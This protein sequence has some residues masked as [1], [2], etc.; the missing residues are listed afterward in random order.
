MPTTRRSLGA[1]KPLNANI[2][3][4]TTPGSKVSHLKAELEKKDSENESLRTDIQNLAK[5][6]GKLDLVKAAQPV[7]N[8]AETNGKKDPKAPAP[9]KTA[10]KYFCD[11]TPAQDNMQQVWKETDATKRQPFVKLAAAD[12]ERYQNEFAA[13]KEEKQAMDMY[14][15][16]KKQDQA[17]AFY[18]AHLEA[19][20]ALNKAEAD[21][22][23]KK[24]MKD[25]NAPKRPTSSY[26]YYAMD[27]RGSVVVTNPDAKPTEIT[28]M[29]GS[30]WNNLE[31]KKAKKFEKMAETDRQRYSAEKQAYDAKLAAQ[32]AEAEKEEMARLEEEKKEAMELLEST[33]KLAG[34]IKIDQEN[35]SVVSEISAK[36]KKDPNAPK[37]ALTAYN[38]FFT[39]NR[40]NIKSKMPAETTNG[41]L[42]TEVG[43][44]WKALAD[45]KKKKYNK[46]AEKDKVRYT[47]EVAKY[48]ASKE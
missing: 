41:E 42:M 9:A 7:V 30:M 43:R 22:N 21:K 3:A 10:Y 27:T 2:P 32:K 19:Q 26:M 31:K 14:Y 8:P 23:G 1:L 4:P 37:R 11:V 35:M 38:F 47:K 48:N 12:K 45:S 36:K 16:K 17:M 15:E 34:E 25:P 39:E 5:A 29:L 44:Q 13:Y 20:A 24:A 46:M 28:K 33:K 40:E 18:E 6:L